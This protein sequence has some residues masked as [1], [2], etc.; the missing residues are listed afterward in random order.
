MNKIYKKMMFSVLTV[1]GFDTYSAMAQL[2]AGLKS[3]LEMTI[4]CILI[5]QF[6]ISGTEEQNVQGAM[7]PQDIVDIIKDVYSTNVMVVEENNQPRSLMDIGRPV[8]S[9]SGTP[10]VEHLSYKRVRMQRIAAAV[11]VMAVGLLLVV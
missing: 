8:S 7:N 5:L 6:L 9:R 1:V 11:L 4:I 10:R 3:I 2:D